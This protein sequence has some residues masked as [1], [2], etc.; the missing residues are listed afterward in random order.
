MRKNFKYEFISMRNYILVLFLK[1]K[2]SFKITMVLY[3]SL[4][5]FHEHHSS[6]WFHLIIYVV[7]FYQAFK[8]KL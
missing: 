2:L 7:K 6:F 4:F 1:C 5:E 3:F 8:I